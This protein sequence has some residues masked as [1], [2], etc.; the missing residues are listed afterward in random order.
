[1][2][3]TLF[4][5]F[6]FSPEVLGYQQIVGYKIP[7]FCQILE[8]STCNHFP[9]SEQLLNFPLLSFVKNTHP[10]LGHGVL[11]QSV[12]D[13]HH[14]EVLGAEVEVGGGVALERLGEEKQEQTLLIDLML[15]RHY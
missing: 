2:I 3:L 13:R 5:G 4:P 9:N 11:R 14:Q 1:M 7:P 6:F 15:N 8:T 12:V 10:A